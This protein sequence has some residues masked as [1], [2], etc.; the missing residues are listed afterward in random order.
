MYALRAF[1]CHE[2]KKIPVE[3]KVPLRADS[4]GYLFFLYSAIFS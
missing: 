4:D 2:L 3:I 1:Y